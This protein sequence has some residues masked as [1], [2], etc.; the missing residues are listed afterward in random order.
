MNQPPRCPK[1]HTSLRMRGRGRW[2]I[3]RKGSKYFS[4]LFCSEC[5]KWVKKEDAIC[6]GVEKTVEVIEIGKS[7]INLSGFK[8]NAL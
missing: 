7:E 2:K 5:F 1:C 8:T 6:N 3:P 4:Y